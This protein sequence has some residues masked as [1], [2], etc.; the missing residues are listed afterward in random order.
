[1]NDAAKAMPLDLIDYFIV[2]EIEG[3]AL[4]QVCDP[5]DILHALL[6]RYPKSGIVLT[7]GNSGVRY[8]DADQQL[9]QPAFPVDVIDTTGAGD[10][11]TGYFLAELTQTSQV[12]QALTIAAAAAAL[13]VTKAGAATSIP[14]RTEVMNFIDSKSS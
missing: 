9:S 4:T 2:N 7:L 12:Q 5:D 3:E 10:T 6:Q 14:N 13:S 1:M 11:F 8:R